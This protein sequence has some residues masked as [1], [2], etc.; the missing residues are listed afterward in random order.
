LPAFWPIDE[1]PKM[2]IRLDGDKLVVSSD[3]EFETKHFALHTLARWWVNGK[4][5]VPATN[6]PIWQ[7]DLAGIL[8]HEKEIRFDFDFR[9]DRLEAKLGD[10][11]GMQVM[12]QESHWSY[13]V[14]PS[15]LEAHAESADEAGKVQMSN[16]IEFVVR[17]RHLREV[18]SP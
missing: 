18:R 3:T 5:F 16:R 15:L 13:C 8:V 6:G 7:F 12:Y 10:K 14:E 4:P 11:I 2:T 1:D 17:D 9:A